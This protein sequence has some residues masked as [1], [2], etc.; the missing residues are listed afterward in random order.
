MGNAVF[1]QFLQS[2][3]KLQHY[4]NHL[5]TRKMLFGVLV[6]AQNF[7]QT[8]LSL[9]LCDIQLA[10]LCGNTAKEQQIF[11]FYIFG[12]LNK[13]LKLFLMVFQN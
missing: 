3:N 2:V 1:V 13:L 12:H 11:M 8:T 5:V 6:V 7:I 4:I 9:F 10:I